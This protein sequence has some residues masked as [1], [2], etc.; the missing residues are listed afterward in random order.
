MRFWPRRKVYLDN[1]PKTH[2]VRFMVVFVLGLALVLGALYAVGYA[3]AGNKLPHGTTV[4]QVDV[5]GMTPDQAR[6]VLQEKLAPRLQKPITATAAGK[7]YTLDPQVS[8]LT[9]DIDATLDQASGGSAW[10]PRHMLHVLMGGDDL[11][12]KV[13]VD[14]AELADTLNRIAGD[15]ERRA[16]DSVVTFQHAA[17]KVSFG[18]AGRAL[19]FQR[20]GD[21]MIAALVA[22]HRHVDLAM[23]SVQPQ[24]TAI[25]ATRFVDQE[26]K[27]ALS[28]PI[29]I[30]VAD[31]SMVLKPS[32]F[33]SALEAL[34]GPEGLRLDVDAATLMDRASG[35]LSRLPHHPVNAR[36][37]FV[38]DRPRI[39]PASAGVTVDPADFATAV[40]A[41]V[42]EKGDKRKA[43]TEPVPDN[44]NVT[45]D[46]IRTMRIKERVSSATQRFSTG[47]GT[48]DPAYQI[49]RLDGALIKPGGEFS[50][51]KR[52]PDTASPAASFVASMAY[53]VAFEA[54]LDIPEH[55]SA[56]IYTG[57]FAAGRD[58]HVEPPAT[59]L[60]VVNSTPY[61]VYLRAFVERPA[62]DRSRARIAHLE[63]WSTAYWK[64][65]SRSS[66]HYNV[67][68]P[69]VVKNTRRSCVPRDGRAG[70]DIDVTR[71]LTRDGHKRSDVSHSSYAVL[72]QVRCT[73]KPARPRR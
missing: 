68:T 29:T 47:S 69:D 5:G 41:A 48:V 53:E 4:A 7:D 26:A 23:R 35:A 64:V 42:Q 18:R 27:R 66:D 43:R 59:D 46:D 67:I 32:M 52:M 61:G 12:P 58:A 15:V 3:V 37:R 51:L 13:S 17:A 50:Y 11:D 16:E 8:G 31:S 57:D 40:L 56:R 72:D 1:L 63:L 24:V 71:V 60:V 30:K 33:G 38:G 49:S 25:T 28:G 10:D 34:P 36:I 44:P 9:F 45:T 22:G 73:A 20:S 55:T 62:G 21:R 19:D 2:D 65:R 6:T 39:V 54:G 70:F 14:D